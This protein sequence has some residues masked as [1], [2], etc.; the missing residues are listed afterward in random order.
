MKALIFAAARIFGSRRTFGLCVLTVLVGIRLADPALLEEIRLR[1]FDLFQTLRPRGDSIQ[2]VVIVDI[3][4]ASLNAY[5]QFPWPRTLIA[6]LLTR[7]FEWQS[8]AVA[9]DIIFPEPDRSSPNEAMKYFRNIDQATRDRLLQ[10]PNNDD[11]LASVIAN[12]RVV[13]GQSGTHGVNASAP[14]GLPET[15][16]ATVGPDPGPYLIAFPRLLRNLPQLER[17]AAGRGLFTIATERDGMVRRVPLIMKADEK[18]VTALTVDLLRVALGAPAVLVRTDQ[19]GVRSVALMGLELPT[20]P[21]GRVWIHFG[22]HDK[23]RYVSAKD[24]IEGTAAPDRFAGKLVLIGTSAIGLLDIKTTPVD[25]AM[26]GV[27]VHAQLLEAALAKSLLNMP[28][29]M[30][31]VELLGAIIAGVLLSLL[32][33]IVSAR[34]L[35]AIA[36]FFMAAFIAAAWILYNQNQTLFDP[37]FPLIAT[38][39]IY[40][41][42][43]LI[44]YFRE[45]IDRQRIRSAFAQYLSPNLVEELANSPEKVALG[46]QERDMTVLFSDVRG[47]TTI[48]ET[49]ARDPRGLTTLMNRFL[50]P[51]TNA[52]VAR[53]G[54]IDKYIG[55]AVMAFW[56][57]PLDDP[58][59]EVHACY[60]ALDMLERVT[61]LNRE[62]EREALES[63]LRFVPI[64]MGIGINTGRCVVGN[65]GS[66]MRFQYTVMGDSVNLASRLEGQTAAYGLPVLIGSKT[67]EAVSDKLALLQVDFIRVKGKTEPDLIYTIVGNAEIAKTD[68]FELLRDRWSELLARYRRQDWSGVTTIIECSRDLCQKFGLAELTDVYKVRSFQFSQIPPPAD[69]DGVYIAGTK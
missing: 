38:F 32:A 11:V 19:A 31:V 22:P 30:I 2:P 23:T 27:E 3:D 66:E 10:L 56:N 29:A 51:L 43:A 12:G 14:E 65:M 48:S 61:T 53:D 40:I 25:P 54:T 45:Q 59:H 64:K 35:L 33:S 17:A 63:G 60:A 58:V 13:L 49:Y 1:T 55:D 16:I 24:V 52:I 28:G 46:G 7:L 5:G 9:F 47:F 4:E 15:A 21:N 6:D 57:A 18:M 41:G 67:A 39:S 20:D 68:D 62:R 36:V 37:T 50:T 26:P 44:G 8:A 42:L 34:M 69:W